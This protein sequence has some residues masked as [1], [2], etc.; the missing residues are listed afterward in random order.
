MKAL[1]ILTA[2]IF[3]VSVMA[4]PSP[5]PTPEPEAPESIGT[6]PDEFSE[7]DSKE[8][9]S[10]LKEESDKKVVLNTKP[11]AKKKS[12]PVLKSE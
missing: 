10:F 7:G 11:S 3:Q 4:A 2:F 5:T 1:L 6:Q 9:E 12:S 8:L